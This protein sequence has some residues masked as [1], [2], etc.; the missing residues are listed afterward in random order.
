MAIARLLRLYVQKCNSEYFNGF[1][2]MFAL[3]MRISTAVVALAGVM[4]AK[5]AFLESGAA[6]LSLSSLQTSRSDLTQKRYRSYLTR[7]EHYY[8]SLSSALKIDLQAD[9]LSILESPRTVDFG[10]QR[11][12]NISEDKRPHDERMGVSAYSWPWTDK[13]IDDAMEE[14]EQSMAALAH[15]VELTQAARGRLYETLTQRF[16]QLRSRIQNIDA[17]VQY[18]RLWQ[19]AVAERRASYDRER[20]LYTLVLDREAIR[21]LLR[22]S[23]DGSHQTIGEFAWSHTIQNIPFIEKELRKREML[24]TRKIDA[25]TGGVEVPRFVRVERG[26][27]LW[28]F[29]VPFYTD[30]ENPDFL[31]LIKD[32]IESVWHLRSGEDEFRVQLTF[33][34]VSSDRLYTERETPRAGSKISLS[35]HLALFPPDGAVLTT[36][37]LTTHVLG[38]AIVLGPQN[39]SARVLAHEVGHVLGFRDSYVRSYR[40]LGHDGFEVMEVVAESNDIM[41]R[42]DNG[43]VLPRHFEKMRDQLQRTPEVEAR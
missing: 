30:I 35:E 16:L 36:G 20:A 41:A 24:L 43:V 42:S 8:V 5:P 13:L 23:A 4:F 17:H 14:M 15:A 2:V 22:V 19:T 18:N 31:A 40:D 7:L 38:R 10:Y 32:K 6:K 26:P 25:A 29:H 34:I 11:L 3:K 33:T 1:D 27:G 37:A 28:I 12:P 39:I 9:L 21:K